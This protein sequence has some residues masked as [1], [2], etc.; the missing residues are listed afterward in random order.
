[1]IYP[2]IM[3]GDNGTRLWPMSRQAYPKQFCHL[4]I[5]DSGVP[6]CK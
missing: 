2:V 6:F 4:P 3:A 1:M 5:A